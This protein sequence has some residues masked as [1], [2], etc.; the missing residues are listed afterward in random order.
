MAERKPSYHS[1]NGD[2]LRT[3]IKARVEQ[4]ILQ[5]MNLRAM[6]AFPLVS[7]KVTIEVIPFRPQGT[8]EPIPD[9]KTIQMCV[10][11]GHE[12]VEVRQDAIELIHDSPIIGWEK[13]PQVERQE[14][15]LG[16][17]ETKRVEGQYVD[18]SVGQ[19]IKIEEPELPPLRGR[20]PRG[21]ALPPDHKP[22][23]VSAGLKSGPAMQGTGDNPGGLPPAEVDR[24]ANLDAQAWAQPAP[25]ADLHAA[26][27]NE[28]PLPGRVSVLKK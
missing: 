13:D 12:F 19:K 3:I 24:I 20:G 27:A 22:V 14:T 2:E 17:I 9:D 18:V 7:Y 21:Q 1:L 11:E 4:G 8:R 15:G 26:I 10:V 5:A 16:K 28:E 23:D 25:D 6:Y